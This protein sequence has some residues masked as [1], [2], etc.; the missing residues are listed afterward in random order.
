MGASQW[1]QAGQAVGAWEV[2]EAG[3]P[4]ERVMERKEPDSR[5]NENSGG[6]MDSGGSSC[7]IQGWA[8]GTLTAEPRRE[9]VQ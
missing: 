4:D 9:R 3:V 6:G 2:L 5:W 7:P 8:E 1:D